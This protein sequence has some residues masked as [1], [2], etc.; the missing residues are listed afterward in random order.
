MMLDQD[1]FGRHLKTERDKDRERKWVWGEGKKEGKEGGRE[2]EREGRKEDG[3]RT[4]TD[5]AT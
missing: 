1:Y 2:G 5:R 3:G 4:E